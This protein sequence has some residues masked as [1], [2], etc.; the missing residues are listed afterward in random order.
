MKR[1]TRSWIAALCA[2]LWIAFLAGPAV[3]AI[4]EVEITGTVTSEG[5]IIVGED[6]QYL[7]EE[8][9]MKPQI[10]LHVGE[11]VE[12]KGTIEEEEGEKVIDVEEFHIID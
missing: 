11:K 2:L 6:E 3:Y 1:K 10:M 9:E 7:I 4:D 5:M 12:V 8:D